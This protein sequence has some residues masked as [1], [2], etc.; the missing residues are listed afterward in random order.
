MIDIAEINTPKATTVDQTPSNAANPAETPIDTLLLEIAYA[1]LAPLFLEAAG[2]N[3]AFARNA[4]FGMIASYRATCAADLLCVVQIIA[5]ALASLRTVM[6]TVAE[7]VPVTVVIRAINSAQRLARV[8]EQCRK[9]RQ[10][11]Y[12]RDKP[13]RDEPPIPT[14]ADLMREMAA[15]RPPPANA[16]RSNAVPPGDPAASRQPAPPSSQA[17]EPFLHSPTM[18]PQLGGLMLRIEKQGLQ[19]VSKPGPGGPVQSGWR[20][21]WGDSAARVA[22]QFLSDIESLPPQQRK[23]TLKQARTLQ[24]VA[25]ELLS[26]APLPDHPDWPPS[27]AN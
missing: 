14:A 7:D 18:P 25:Q 12:G 20:K 27:P 6:L 3:V 13:A 22:C 23:E 9:S 19:P 4:A 16:P 15:R 17:W 21:V 26:G 2:G 1:L 8:E 10:E 5:Y 24:Y 11:Y